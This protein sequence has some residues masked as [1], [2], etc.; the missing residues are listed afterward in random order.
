[1]FLTNKTASRSNSLTVQMNRWSSHSSGWQMA[2]KGKAIWKQ[3]DI[4]VHFCMRGHRCMLLVINKLWFLYQNLS[5]S[6]YWILVHLALSILIMIHINNTFSYHWSSC[7]GI[8]VQRSQ[9]WGVFIYSNKMTT[10]KI[11]A[12]F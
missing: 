4:G 1:M 7:L 10:S 9:F 3:K 6:W 11:K 5:H 12:S 8:Q 2:C